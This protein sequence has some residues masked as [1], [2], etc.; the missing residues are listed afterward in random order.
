MRLKVSIDNVRAVLRGQQ[1]QALWSTTLAA[2]PLQAGSQPL[3]AVPSCTN[4]GLHDCAEFGGGCGR[5][6]KANIPSCR[7]QVPPGQ[8]S[9][10]YTQHQ[11]E[12]PFRASGAL[13]LRCNR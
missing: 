10:Q 4:R 13:H 6:V 11:W 9:A 1:R 3:G 5:R 8:G 7:R 2:P 12:C